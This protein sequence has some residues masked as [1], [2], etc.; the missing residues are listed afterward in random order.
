MEQGQIR[1]RDDVAGTGDG[2]DDIRPV[3]A[4]ERSGTANPSRCASSRF[5][6]SVSTTQTVAKACL[7]LT[8]TPLPQAP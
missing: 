1:R 8:A 3:S 5:T 7:K 2:D 4:S 6:G